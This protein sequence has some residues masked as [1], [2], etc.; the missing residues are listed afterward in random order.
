[1]NS[2]SYPPPEYR[3]RQLS[4]RELEAE[5]DRESREVGIPLSPK[6][7]ERR[8]T[9]KA[10]LAEGDELWFWEYFP[11][12]LTGGAGYCIV[13]DGESV[14]RC[15][16]FRAVSQPH[17]QHRDQSRTEHHQFG[18]DQHPHHQIAGQRR[19]RV[20]RRLAHRSTRWR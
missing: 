11:E 18:Q 3:K 20:V 14:A 5:L 12:P 4:L 9:F 1:M 10:Q 13:R 7:L 19:T 15:R 16:K 17:G 2:R 8:E 6:W